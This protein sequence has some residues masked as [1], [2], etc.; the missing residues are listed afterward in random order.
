[1]E[2]LASMRMGRLSFADCPR[3]SALRPFSAAPSR[4][5]IRHRQRLR[6]AVTCSRPASAWPS[7]STAA[8]A[9]TVAPMPTALW[10]FDGGQCE[11][12]VQ[13][14]LRPTARPPEPSL[15][16][17]RQPSRRL[18]R[19]GRRSLGPRRR[20][21]GW[22][23]AAGAEAPRTGAGRLLPPPPP[24]PPVPLVPPGP[25]VPLPPRLR[26]RLDLPELCFRWRWG[27]RLYPLPEAEAAGAS[28]RLRERSCDAAQPP[29]ATAPSP[30]GRPP[31]LDSRCSLS[32][33]ASSRY[34]AILSRTS[35]CSAPSFNFGITSRRYCKP[36]QYFSYASSSWTAAS[37]RRA[38]AMRPSPLSMRLRRCLSIG[39]APPP[40]A[41]LPSSV[42]GA[43]SGSGSAALLP[44][45]QPPL[46]PPLAS[47]CFFRRSASSR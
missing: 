43:A 44:A 14:A 21:E 24:V 37:S 8:F 2:R 31:P 7:N 28:P 5:F 17:S 15:R 46:P 3:P 34:P 39:S 29:E 25:P 35:P 38:S 36:Q 26:L 32:R 30:S 4:R 27:P 42:L 33:S 45:P 11:S 16:R 9:V 13:A 12:W 18:G 47:S 40:R 41:P 6:R 10:S 22:A 19:L 23:A 20:D 1:M